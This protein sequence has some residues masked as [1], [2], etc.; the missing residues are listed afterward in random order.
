MHRVYPFVTRHWFY[1]IPFY[2]KLMV[3]HFLF[4]VVMLFISCT[5]FITRIYI[6]IF[7]FRAQRKNIA[8]YCYL[9][10]SFLVLVRT[11]VFERNINIQSYY[12]LVTNNI[13]NKTY[14]LVSTRKIKS[15]MLIMAIKNYQIFFTIKFFKQ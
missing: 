14:F 13:L 1:C 7:H 3:Y 4:V 6:Y 9:F 10:I 8:N 12:I 2:L 5:I 11:A 15:R